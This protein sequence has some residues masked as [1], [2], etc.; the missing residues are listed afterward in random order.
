MREKHSLILVLPPHCRENLRKSVLSVVDTYDPLGA[1]SE[2]EEEERETTNEEKENAKKIDYGM[3]FKKG[4]V[5]F[6]LLEVE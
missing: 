2:K 4:V 5:T 3:W 6:V 1:E